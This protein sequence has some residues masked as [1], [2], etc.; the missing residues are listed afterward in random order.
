MKILIRLLIFA[1]ICHNIFGQEKKETVHLLFDLSSSEKCI[2]EDGSGNELKVK[3]YRKYY[4]EDFTFFK[5]FDEEFIFRHA[6]Q[7]PDTCSIN[8]LKKINFKTIEYLLDKYKKKPYFKK[9]IIYEKISNAKVVK[10]S[11]VNWYYFNVVEY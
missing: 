9:I 2:V 10:Y 5:I 11:D 4:D 6:L 3:K 8:D 7:K 1:L